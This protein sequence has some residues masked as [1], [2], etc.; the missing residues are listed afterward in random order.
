MRRTFLGLGLATVLAL[1]Y[2]QQR[3]ML[4]TVGYELE[5]LRCLKDDLLDQ[6][7][8][9][10]YNVLTLQSP[11]ILNRRLEEHQVQLK[12]PKAVEILVPRDLLAEGLRRGE[13]TSW[14]QRT[15]ELAVRWLG[16]TRQAEAKPE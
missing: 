14:I 8:V 11:V 4:V 13:A 6:N 16:S 9:L 5:K 1:G 12:P 7:R 15:R 2:V 3:V 10:N